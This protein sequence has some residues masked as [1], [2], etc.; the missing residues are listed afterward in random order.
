MVLA[1]PEKSPILIQISDNQM[2]LFLSIGLFFVFLGTGICQITLNQADIASPGDIIQNISPP[3]DG[4][5]PPAGANQTYNFMVDSIGT[6]DTTYFVSPSSTPYGAQMS[7]ANLASSSFGA[8]SYYEKDATGF[9]LRGM[10]LDFPPVVPNQPFS[11]IPLRFNPRIALLTFPTTVGMNL[12]TQSTARFR[13]RYDTVLTVL[14]QQATVDSVEIV[15]T[16]RDTSTIEGYGTAEFPSGNLPTLRNR[17]AQNLSFSIRVRAKVGI[18]PAFWTA[19]PV[20]NLPTFTTVNYLFWANGKKA[21]VAQLDVDSLGFVIGASFQSELLSLNTGLEELKNAQ[22][23]QPFPNPVREW[24]NI[25]TASKERNVE[26]FSAEGKLI[27]EFLVPA[28]AKT[29][30][31]APLTPGLYWLEWAG[32]DR[33]KIRKKLMVK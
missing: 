28:G 4:D 25:G 13:F 21:P 27:K 22:D 20:P 2:K 1:L 9:Y 26:I 30:N 7:G 6:S 24:V 19:F 18:L 10:V 14:G 29:I 5:L 31:V 12:K 8:Y 11:L 3:F 15:F 23:F 16:V 32:T 33:Q 17:N